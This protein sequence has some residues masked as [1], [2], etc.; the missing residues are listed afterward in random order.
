[1]LLGL[2]RAVKGTPAEH[3]ANIAAA[4]SRELKVDVPVIVKSARELAAIVSENTLAR[5][6]FDPAR[7]LVAFV[8]D[9]KALLSLRA[10]GD[11]TRPPD[12]FA[13]GGHAAYLMC[14]T[15]L[16]E[17]KAGKALLGKAGRA[18]TT[19]NWST[20]LKLHALAGKPDA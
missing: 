8:Q 2:F 6:A 17:S 1:M 14:T 5:G 18:A 7:L 3:A 19:R 20:T 15:G 10:I 4:I 13:V 11:L 12:R 9:G 16:L